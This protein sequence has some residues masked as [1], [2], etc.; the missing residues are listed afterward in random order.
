MIVSKFADHLPLFRQS[1]IYKRSGVDLSRS[2]LADWVGQVSWLVDPLVQA[3]A[4][5]VFEAGKLHTDDTTLKLLA[6]G[7]GKTKTARLWA[8]V[9]D[10]RNWHQGDPPAAVYYYSPDRKS[11]HPEQH[12][13]S[14]SG[15][16]QADAYA[17]Y[18]KLYDPH[19]R[20]GRII[21]VG[22]WAHARRKLV[23]IVKADSNSVAR[24]GVALIAKLYD[25]EDTIRG[26]ELDVR[27]DA[28]KASRAIIEQFFAWAMS[29]VNEVSRH[30]PLT[31]ALQ[32]VLQRKDA[33]LR[34]TEDPTLEI[35]NNRAENSLRPVAL[36]RKNFLFAGAD[37]G[38]ERA[39]AMY[40]LIETAR[41]N[42][43]EPEHWLADVLQRLAEGHKINAINELLPWNWKPEADKS[44]GRA[45]I[46][47]GKLHP[48]S[49]GVH[50]GRL[51]TLTVNELIRVLANLGD[52]PLSQAAVVEAFDDASLANVPF[53]HIREIALDPQGDDQLVGSVDDPVDRNKLHFTCEP[54][55]DGSY[56][57]IY[58]RRRA[59]L[60]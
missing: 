16:L 57:L 19:R 28:R 6:P 31:G 41:L 29:I 11:V 48:F 25:I 53:G 33:F 52:R 27:R 21:G 26:A 3:I 23:D 9:R 55:P 56:D 30:S 18:E 17:G 42:G 4:N 43:V 49:N 54:Q 39:A 15:F 20:Q 59:G 34:Y 12:L 45:G 32:Y 50:E 60:D 8:Y 35:D 58:L 40:S 47:I 36:G 22:C 37:S 2:T 7:S 1:N 44:Q 10:N 14:F 38:G 24:R 13:R 46:V 5:H 51:E